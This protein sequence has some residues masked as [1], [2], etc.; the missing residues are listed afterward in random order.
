MK[1]ISIQK[2]VRLTKKAIAGVPVQDSHVAG[3]KLYA[4]NVHKT[5]YIRRRVNG[6][7][8]DFKVCRW[9]ADMPMERIRSLAQSLSVDIAN[10]KLPGAKNPQGVTFG[11]AFER[12]IETRRRGEKA[13]KPSPDRASAF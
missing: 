13:I 6:S 11:Q 9:D 10:G 1:A 8:R 5:L 7:N 3:M 12:Y 2:P 4:G